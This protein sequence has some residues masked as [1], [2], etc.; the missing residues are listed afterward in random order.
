MRVCVLQNF[1]LIVSFLTR[2]INDDCSSTSSHK[3]CT[4]T[5]LILMQKGP[6]VMIL[7]FSMKMRIAPIPF[8]PIPY[9]PLSH[10]HQH[11]LLF[12]TSGSCGIHLL[13]AYLT[14]FIIQLV[15]VSKVQRKRWDVHVLNNAEIHLKKTGIYTAQLQYTGIFAALSGMWEEPLLAGQSRSYPKSSEELVNKYS[16]TGWPACI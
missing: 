4:L 3:Y 14:W 5:H 11:W 9:I 10:L 12:D 2:L 7:I 15:L 1:S 16:G 6:G 13:S 8:Q